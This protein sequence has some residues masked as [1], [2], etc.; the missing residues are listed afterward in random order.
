MIYLKIN[1]YHSYVSYSVRGSLFRANSLA[2][3]KVHIDSNRRNTLNIAFTST[4][5]NDFICYYFPLN[6]CFAKISQ[7][8]AIHLYIGFCISK[9]NAI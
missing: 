7:I 4:S 6:Q 3:G 8:Y 5:C 1:F 9:R 2:S